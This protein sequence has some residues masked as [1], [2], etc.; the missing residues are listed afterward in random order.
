MSVLACGKEV[1]V[2]MERERAGDRRFRKRL[3]GLPC[4]EE[5]EERYRRLLEQV[6]DAVLVHSE[7]RVVYANRAAV[8]LLG[9]GRVEDLLGRPVLDL[10]HPD[11]RDMVRQRIREMQE[12]G[13]PVGL[14]E[15]KVVRLDSEVVEVEVCASPVAWE[16][17]PAVQVVGR[18]ITEGRRVQERIQYLAYHDDLTG[19][20]NARYFLE[21]LDRHA[22]FA[23][24]FPYKGAVLYLDVDGLNSVNHVLGYRAGNAVLTAM[25]GLIQ[26]QVREGLDL[27]ARVG[28]EEF[29]VLIPHG[30]AEQ[31]Y[32]TGERLR[33]VVERQVSTVEGRAV[34]L[35]VSIGVAC[36]PE[37]GCA[38]EKVLRCAE[39]ALRGRGQ[40]RNG[41]WAYAP[42]DERLASVRSQFEWMLR[43]RENMEAD[44]LLLYLQPILDLRTASVSPFEALL[45]MVGPD[46]QIVMPGVFLF[47]A[48]QLGQSRD[49]DRWVIRQAVALLAQQQAQG[50]DLV[51]EVNLSGSSLCDRELLAFI[52]HELASAGASP[53][54]L[55]FE[56]TE[57]AAVENLDEERRFTAA[58][59]EMGCRF[60]LDD[61]GVGQSSFHQLNSLPVDYLKID[62]AFVRDLAHS[63][64]DRV[65]V[66][67]IVDL[68]HG[69]GMETIAEF[70]R[71]GTAWRPSRA[72]GSTMPRGT[73]SGR[74]ARRD[75]FWRTGSR[76]SRF[77][78]PLLGLVRPDAR[79]EERWKAS[80]VPGWPD[81]M[82]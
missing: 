59:K 51:L 19:L 48:E 9:A 77:R 26:H 11:C 46:G 29:A 42:E 70:V 45:R 43:I 35:T 36:L 22:A 30:D 41:I 18:D 52:G 24:R 37:H 2:G 44:R 4:A 33:R 23:S 15:E 54:G 49:I 57:T 28:N 82:T 20:P 53:D 55:V 58:L 81:R 72:S 50:R 69:L 5:S 56:I 1:A 67:A 34:R 75:R 13:L 40:R 47:A 66:R 32:A 73:R 17:R 80:M 6:D 7:G 63:N 38:G 3:V 21:Q 74:P 25:A 31:A 12:S 62:G 68:A 39:M 14:A 60:A 78:P 8:D 27:V 10:V 61:F 64:V 16:G 76:R 71:D 65:L 79:A